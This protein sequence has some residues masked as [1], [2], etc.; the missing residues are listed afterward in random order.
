MPP[1]DTEMNP[2]PELHMFPDAQARYNTVDEVLAI[3][4]RAQ[5]TN[6]G[7]I[8]NDQYRQF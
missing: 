8:G 1:P 7:F 3:T 5:V 4:R 6:M 2:V